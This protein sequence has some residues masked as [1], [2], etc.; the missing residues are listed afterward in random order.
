MLDTNICIYL[1]KKKFPELNLKIRK[2]APED[3]AISS[4]VAS[5]L[6]YG[7]YKSKTGNALNMVNLFLSTFEILPFDENAA[8]IFG[9]IK[10][11]LSQSGSLIG[12]FDMQIAAHAV[13]VNAVLITNNMK[14]FSKVEILN[15]ENWIPSL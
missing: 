5:E 13:T 15:C 11:T 8:K 14:E 1:I 10:A 2:Y 3:F 7:A 4:V 6:Y 9:T 12:P